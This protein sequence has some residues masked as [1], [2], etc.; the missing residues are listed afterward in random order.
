MY[1]AGGGSTASFGGF[2]MADTAPQ[3]TQSPSS[4]AHDRE[5]FARAKR[6]VEAIKGF[7]IHLIIFVLVLALLTVINYATGSPWWV[8]WVFLGWGVGVVG[9]AIGVYGRSPRMFEDW[10]RRKLKKLMEER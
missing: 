8:Q 6:Q 3:P 9:H 10:E 5:K 7:Y 4:G 1:A 2:A